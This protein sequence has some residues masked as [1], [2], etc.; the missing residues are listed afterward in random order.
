MN[1]RI[2]WSMLQK[3]KAKA[4]LENKIIY[5]SS[6]VIVGCVVFPILWGIIAILSGIDL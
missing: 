5:W 4:D 3:A 1:N 2:T 6:L